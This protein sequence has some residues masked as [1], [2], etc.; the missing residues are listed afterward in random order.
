MKLWSLQTRVLFLVLLPGALIAV[1]L[2]GYFLYGRF[3]DLEQALFDRGRTIARQLGPAAQYGLFSGSR[4]ELLRLASATLQEADVVAV[5]IR[6][7]DD[8]VLAVAGNP[9]PT[10]VSIPPAH[11]LLE[12]DLPVQ[13]RRA[14]AIAVFGSALALEPYFEQPARTRRIGT[15]SVEMSLRDLS[16]RKRQQLSYSGAVA[17]IILLLG[18]LAAIRMGRSL[19]GPIRALSRTVSA[20]AQ[21]DLTVRA[22]EHSQAEFLTLE[23]GVNQMAVALSSSHRHL[24]QRISE[25]TAE[26]A[27]RKEQAEQSSASKTRFL[28]AASHDLR[29]PMQA[30]GLWVSALRMQAREPVVQEMSVKIEASVNVLGEMLNALLD[31][32]KLDAGSVRPEVRTV[33]LDFL[34]E[35]LELQFGAQARAKG[36]VLC[37]RRCALAV[38][39]DPALLNRILHNLLANA[40]KYT[41]DGRVLLCARLRGDAVRVEVRDSGPGIPGPLQSLIFEEFFQVDNP[42]RDRDKGLGLG[43]AIVQ[44]LTRL[45]DHRCELRSAPGRGS[46]FAVMAPVARLPVPQALPAPTAGASDTSSLAGR[47]IA[48]LDDDPLVRTSLRDLLRSHGCDTLSAGSARELFGLLQQGSR[49]PDLLICD[50]RL[51]DAENGV[52]VIQRTRQTLGAKLPCLLISGDL[53]PDVSRLAQ[54]AQ[55]RLLQKPVQAQRLVQALVTLLRT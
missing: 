46:T 11:D 2:S 27:A 44:R 4:E 30:L 34:F 23:R 37:V 22:T 45:L 48:L 43:L 10:L 52:E 39:T 19:T 5:T 26:L 7:A 49:S 9:T 12:T 3:G 14:F 29:Q 21:G 24:Q 55:I 17:A 32:S 15:V 40:I 35:R 41:T 42:E 50:Y 13:Q 53:D 8:A 20:L 51:P 31:I 28:A 16:D 6:G 54:S 36:L 47:L 18:T 38:R 1:L 25:A 33:P